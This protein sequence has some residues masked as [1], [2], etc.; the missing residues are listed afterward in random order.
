M[1]ASLLSPKTSQ[2]AS[3]PDI[4]DVEVVTKLLNLHGVEVD[5]DKTE[6]C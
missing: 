5:F 2:L 3:V 6:A 1:V 4:R